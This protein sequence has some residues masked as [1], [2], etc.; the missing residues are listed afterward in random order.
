MV[1]KKDGSL[2]KTFDALLSPEEAERF[3]K[4]HEPIR[5]LVEFVDMQHNNVK[6]KASKV[7]TK[8][9]QEYKNAEQSRGTLSKAMTALAE[10]MGVTDAKNAAYIGPMK[11]LKRTLEKLGDDQGAEIFDLG[12]GRILVR[13]PDKFVNLAKI[14]KKKDEDG[15]LYAFKS[16]K[17]S[18]IKDKNYTEK[19]SKYGYGGSWNIAALIDLGKNRWGRV[20]MQAMPREFVKTYD[21]SHFLYEIMRL[22]EDA[23]NEKFRTPEQKKVIDV[24]IKANRALFDE[25][26][27]RTGFITLRE[28][29]NL[30]D[31]LEHLTQEEA[32]EVWDVLD[33]M[34]TEIGALSGKDPGWRQKTIQA[35]TNAKTSIHNMQRFTRRLTP[36]TRLNSAAPIDDYPNPV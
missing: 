21:D 23:V 18:I 3:V 27:V 4:L 5:T 8:L 12:R 26:A 13:D 16:D 31:K 11:N 14:L 7:P 24:L 28:G 25:V 19:V 33:Y 2:G 36:T 35:M 30:K 10:E 20:E 29:E 17:V 6:D 22:Q 1:K 15:H 9:T 32:D 34:Q